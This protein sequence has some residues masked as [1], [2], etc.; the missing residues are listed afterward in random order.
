[1]DLP[2]N[3]RQLDAEI[4]QAELAIRAKIV[5]EMADGRG[6]IPEHVQQKIKERIQRDAKKNP[7]MDLDYYEHLAGKLEYADL[8][9]LQ[10][11]I[12]AKINWEMFQGCFASKEL[13]MAKFSQLAELRNRIRHSRAVDQVFLK[14][15]EAALI[16]FKQVL[17][18]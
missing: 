5:A 6:F 18:Q 12:L 11:I 3:L 8:R 9:E 14:E 1:M 17:G 16:W 4:E 2:P 7:A 10:D 13:L 15:G